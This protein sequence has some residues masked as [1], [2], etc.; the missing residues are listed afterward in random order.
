MKSEETHELLDGIHDSELQLASSAAVERQLCT[1]P[2]CSATFNRHKTL[3]T[4]VREAWPH[5][6]ARFA[7]IS[8]PLREQNREPTGILPG[9]ARCALV[10]SHLSVIALGVVTRL[11]LRASS[12]R[13]R[14]HDSRNHRC[15]RA[16]AYP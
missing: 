12:L 13:A 7:R 8:G 6:R 14:L 9:R 5:A 15:A 2:L 4:R 1:C 3:R 11:R 16:L 10:A